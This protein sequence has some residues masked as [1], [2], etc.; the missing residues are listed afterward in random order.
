[1]VS[2]GSMVTGEIT[3][4][5]LYIL[6]MRLLMLFLWVP[7]FS[8]ISENEPDDDDDVLLLELLQLLVVEW[9]C[10]RLPISKIASKF[11]LGK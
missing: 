10:R 1:M 3:G 6:F 4:D 9:G 8:R 5:R 2:F 7:N 11:I